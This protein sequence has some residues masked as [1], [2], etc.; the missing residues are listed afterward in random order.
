M[1]LRP[2]V[3]QAR[4]GASQVLSAMEHQGESEEM[5]ATARATIDEV[6][7]LFKDEGLR[8]MYVQHATGKLAGSST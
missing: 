1:Q 2:M 6:A 5:L 8:E 3:W 4:A 7:A